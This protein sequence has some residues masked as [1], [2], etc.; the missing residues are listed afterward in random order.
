MF[1]TPI[2]IGSPSVQQQDEREAEAIIEGIVEE[3]AAP[4]PDGTPEILTAAQLAELEAA[5]RHAAATA[6]AVRLGTGMLGT[7]INIK[8]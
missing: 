3:S 7:L 5:E 8:V 2:P 1:F 4:P 6:E